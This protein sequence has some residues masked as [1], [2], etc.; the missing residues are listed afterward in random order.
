MWHARWKLAAGLA[1]VRAARAGRRAGEDDAGRGAVDH[2][3]VINRLEA[4]GLD[5][6]YEGDDRTEVMLHGPED[7]QILADTGYRTKVLDDDIDGA[8]DARSRTRRP[9]RSAS[10]RASRRSRRCRPAASPTARWPRSTPSSSS[11]RRPTRPRS[12]CSRSARR[13]CWASRSTA[14]RSA[15]TS[16][17]TSASRRSC[18]PACTTR[19]SG[20]RPSSRSSSSTTC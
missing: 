15:T 5:V 18:S 9:R 7:T 10:R 2:A 12:S 3:A 11:S 20:R 17:R 16:P 13:R 14:S 8:N 1:S 4:L 19:A 6:T